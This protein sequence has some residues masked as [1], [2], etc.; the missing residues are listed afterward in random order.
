MKRLKC[1]LVPMIMV[2]VLVLSGCASGDPASPR[3]I[4]NP[5]FGIGLPTV[6][7]P[8]SVPTSASTSAPTLGSSFQPGDQI[9]VDKAIVYVYHSGGSNY[10]FMLRANGRDIALLRKG[11]YYAYA[12]KPGTIEFTAQAKLACSIALDTKVG[13]AYYLKGSVPSGFALT[14]SLVLVSPEVGANEI[15]NCKLTTTIL[16]STST[17]TSASTPGKTALSAP[18]STSASTLGASFQKEKIL[19]DKAV[20]YIYRPAGS[21]AGGVAIPFGVKAGDKVVTTLSQGGYCAYSTEP[22]QIEFTTFEIGFGAPTST[23]SITVDAKAGQAYYLKGS[24]GK[25]LGGRANLA[26]VS[27]EVGASEIVNCKLTTP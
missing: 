10:P 17:P 8:T 18:A 25:G 14:P 21:G 24:H 11:Q 4:R 12:I 19:A 7:A 9:P 22:G 16:G 5:G 3:R 20:V 15:A 6:L 1:L 27:P 23:S 13:Q 2:G 26:S